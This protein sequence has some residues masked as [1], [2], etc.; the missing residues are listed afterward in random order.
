M[1]LLVAYDSTFEAS[2]FQEAAKLA[3]AFDVFIHVVRTCSSKANGQEIAN[4]EHTLD[5]ARRKY[6]DPHGIKSESHVLIRGMAPGEDLVQFAKEKNIDQIIIGIHRR[7]RVGKL[8]FGSTA[9]YI[10]LSAPCPVLIVR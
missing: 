2:M 7:S 9:Q 10:I 5:E 6:L 3:K 8:V 4:L 1:N